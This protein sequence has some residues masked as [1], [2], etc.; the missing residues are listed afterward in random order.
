MASNNPHDHSAHPEDL[1]AVAA[2]EPPSKPGSLAGVLPN[3][4]VRRLVMG[5]IPLL[6][7][8]FGSG[9]IAVSR[10]SVSRSLQIFGT[11]EDGRA[12]TTRELRAQEVRAELVSGRRNALR[13]AV[14][15]RV[16]KRFER[17]FKATLSL[18]GPATR[19]QALLSARSGPGYAL[20]ANFT[21]PRLRSGRYSLRTVATCG[22]RELSSTVPVKVVSRPLRMPLVETNPPKNGT[23]PPQ[24][25]P[26]PDGVLLEIL[27]PVGRLVASELPE[28]MVVRTTDATG[29]P[30]RV[31]F[32]I[33]LKGG[34]L[35]RARPGMQVVKPTRTDSLGLF[36]FKVLSRRLSLSLEVSYKTRG[37][38][39]ATTVVSFP[40][41]TA[42][43]A[44]LPDRLVARPGE[45]LGLLV[46]TKSRSGHVYLEGLVGGRRFWMASKAVSDGVARLR[47]RVP[48]RPG[49]FRIQATDDFANPGSA[50]ASR[51]LFVDPAKPSD[52]RWLV[53]LARAV[54]AQLP[55]WDRH[56]RAHVDRLLE[57]KLLTHPGTRSGVAAAY[58]LSRLDHQHYPTAWLADTYEADA[59]RTRARRKRLQTYM[60]L[61]LAFTGLLLLGVVGPLVYTNVLLHRQGAAERDALMEEFEKELASG[62]PEHPGTG[63]DRSHETREHLVEGSDRPGL[64]RRAVGRERLARL[65]HRVQIA[66]VA[67]VIILA[68][69]MVLILL[70]NLT[71]SQQ[72]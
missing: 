23:R 15:N 11:A 27:P 46:Q 29:L 48:T 63:G 52:L 53:R 60:I 2:W 51:T 16:R 10:L 34:M 58:L 67:G 25:P 4:W 65:Q 22:G 50:L 1:E 45:H 59:R 47:V 9:L 49:L 62:R 13:V 12:T 31:Q 54:R 36:G 21:L 33:K 64:D 69:T 72:F 66:M 56:T 14:W 44:I 37:G 43:A 3:R 61:G 42:V 71:W 6:A 68:V 7:I 5:A 57:R 8:A 26:G 55:T 20:D 38:Q 40:Q 18:S 39:T 30:V 32:E 41:R 70:L 19:P 28:S 35:Y 17:H 24:S